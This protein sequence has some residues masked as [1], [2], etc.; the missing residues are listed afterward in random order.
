MEELRKQ[1]KKKEE[2]ADVAVEE[3]EEKKKQI[4]TNQPA[5]YKKGLVLKFNRIASVLWYWLMA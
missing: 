4:L 1:K 3:E 2:A 5:P